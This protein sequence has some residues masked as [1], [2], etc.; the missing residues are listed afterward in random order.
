MTQHTTDFCPRQLVTDLLAVSLTNPQQVGN[1]PVHREVT[2][3]RVMDFRNNVVYVTYREDGE[4]GDRCSGDERCSH[5][6]TRT[7][8]TAFGRR[9]RRCATLISGA[10][11]A[12]QPS[13]DDEHEYERTDKFDKQSSQLSYAVSGHRATEQAASIGWSHCTKHLC[14]TERTCNARAWVTVIFTDPSPFQAKIMII[15]N[16]KQ[17]QKQ[18]HRCAIYNKKPNC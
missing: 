10:T 11:G 8:L 12:D 13:T 9:D 17:Q 4:P 3:K 14:S 7:E 1:I 2:R 6:S 5:L 16:H 18:H 15:I